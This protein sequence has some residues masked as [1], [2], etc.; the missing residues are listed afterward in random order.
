MNSPEANLRRWILLL[1]GVLLI[2]LIG[3]VGIRYLEGYSF[4]NA[5]W[6][7]IVS[8]TTTGYGDYYPITTGGKIFMMALLLVGISYV[9]Y[10]VSTSIAMVVE[11]RLSDLM[12]RRSMEKKIAR[13]EGHILICGVGR[14]GIEVIHHLR[15]D[16]VPFVAIE[17]NPGIIEEM[18]DQEV[19]I[20]EGDATRDDMLLKAGIRKARGIVAALPSD[21]DNVFVTLTAKELNPSIFVVARANR[22]DSEARLLRAG[23][24]K[25]IAPEAIGGHRM[26]VS[27]LRPATIDFVDTIMQ[28]KGYDI[29][30]EEIKVSGRSTLKNL[31]MRQAAINDQTGAMV[32]AIMR[33]GEIISVPGGRDL[34]RAGDTLIS[35]GSREQ[36]DKLERLAVGPAS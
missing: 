14:V 8:L 26:A 19:L 27:I 2:I 6:F 17:I 36:L 32:V 23:A 1:A 4:T 7:I 33:D 28:R 9:L 16:Q 18:K 12:G 5:L 22:R 35:I 21:A 20:L 11:G 13:M 24:D 25:V 15:N 3:V 31:S 30:L 34:I 29:Q 10:V